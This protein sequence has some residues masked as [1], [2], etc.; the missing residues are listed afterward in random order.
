MKYEI[1]YEEGEVT[2]ILKKTQ[3]SFSAADLENDNIYLSMRHYLAQDGES[4]ELSKADRQRIAS[5][6]KGGPNE[7]RN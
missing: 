2:F 5:E 7:I 4:L 1:D 6:I 3:V